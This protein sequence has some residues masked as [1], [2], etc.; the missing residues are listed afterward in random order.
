MRSGS[1]GKH[2]STASREAASPYIGQNLPQE[3]KRVNTAGGNR[4]SHPTAA[5]NAPKGAYPSFGP[6][7][8]ATAHSPW[9]TRAY[10]TQE[11]VV[12]AAYGANDSMASVKT[13]GFDPSR[14]TECESFTDGRG[15]SKGAARDRR[16]QK[17]QRPFTADNGGSARVKSA[18]ASLIFKKFGYE[19][20]GILRGTD[21]VWPIPAGPSTT[22]TSAKSFKKDNSRLM[23]KVDKFVEQHVLNLENEGLV[24]FG[25]MGIQDPE[26]LA[27]ETA[28]LRHKK[29]P[30]VTEVFKRRAPAMISPLE[31]A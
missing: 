10:Q 8:D 14:Q 16:A 21:F 30:K 29:N 7:G 26:K 17:P 11:G 20:S 5:R 9:Q 18:A 27:K 24:E 31:M 15:L 25:D 3:L 19:P 2:S 4:R 23:A 12:A 6:A 1:A 22:Y 13:V 28:M